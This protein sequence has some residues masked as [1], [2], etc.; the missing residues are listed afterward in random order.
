MHDLGVPQPV[1]SVRVA[2][3]LHIEAERNFLLS[4]DGKPKTCLASIG[5][6]LLSD[7]TE[8]KQTW[9]ERKN[10]SA[11]RVQLAALYNLAALAQCR[12]GRLDRAE[13]LSRKLIADYQKLASRT[14]C[15]DWAVDALQSYINIARLRG[16]RGDC[17]GCM[18]IL[19][20]VFL[21]VTGQDPL[22]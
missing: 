16:M 15:R 18:E 9:R 19:R 22:T 8:L 2:D 12:Y 7:F 13:S 1:S 6:Q 10:T 11:G 3:L 21:L 17:N 20:H 4:G 5:A 14:G